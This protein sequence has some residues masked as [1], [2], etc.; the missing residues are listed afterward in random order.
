MPLTPLFRG[1][2][3]GEFM[4]KA[5]KKQTAEKRAL[6]LEMLIDHGGNISAACE[7]SGLARCLVY[8]WERENEDFKIAFREAQR[9]GLEVLEDE[10]RRRAFVGTEKPVFHQGIRC[11]SIKE[12]SDT[13]MIFLLKG[14][15]PEKYKDN[16]RID[17]N[18]EGGLTFTWQK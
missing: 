2:C 4:K 11:G 5:D 7:Y 1:V 9:H 13:L 17:H 14:G 15:M 3:S 12:Y 6:F 8:E 16:S 10:A 18:V